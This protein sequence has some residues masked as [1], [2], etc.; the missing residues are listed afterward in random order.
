M[1]QSYRAIPLGL[2][3]LLVFLVV[4]SLGAK[5]PASGNPVLRDR[6]ENEEERSSEVSPPLPKGLVVHPMTGR[7]YLGT[8]QGVVASD[9]DGTHWKPLPTIG[10]GTPRVVSLAL[11]PKD[12]RGLYAATDRN[13]FFYHEA[14]QRWSQVSA[15]LPAGTIQ[16]LAVGREGQVFW[17]RTSQ[18]LFQVP[19]PVGQGHVPTQDIP[20]A[21][22]QQV[23]VLPNEPTAAQVQEIAIR[24]AE[25]MP[26]KIQRWRTGAALRNWIPKFTLS[27]D[28]DTDTTV[29]SS[30]SGG[31]TS[32]SVGPED[33]SVGVGF[34]F[35]WDLANF[36]W[37]PDQTSIDV[38]SR[39]MV[40]LRQ[41]ILE[42]VTRLYFERKRLMAEFEG[43][44]TQDA[45]LQKE[46]SL[47]IEEV[48][49]QIDALTGG[50]FS[51]HIWPSAEN[52]R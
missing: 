36:I 46:R 3:G 43:N 33:R 49:A 22:F 15:K 6:Q 32:F 16:T 17:I 27:L 12:P 28:Q 21:P 44:P 5:A 41:D 7:L 31:K 20:K 34:G 45:I 29:V 26:E 37:N 42:E 48:T 1:K 9:D 25:V 2:C 52:K 8:D 19:I 13:L 51:R 39:L 10:L 11:N 47:K 23:V 24:Y 50:W 18:G 38:R 14:E 35:T 30:T 4:P 40:Q